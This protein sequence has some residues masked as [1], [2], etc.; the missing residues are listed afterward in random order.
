MA[1]NLAKW[2]LGADGVIL[3]KSGGGI[4]EVAMG[5]GAQ[6]CEERGIKTAIALA[7]F[8]TTLTEADSRTLFSHP[9]F[10]AIVSLGTPWSLI[11]LPPVERIIGTSVPSPGDP[12][13]D[14]KLETLLV[15]TRGLLSQTGG[16]RLTAV[17]Y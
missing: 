14:G 2:T 9:E 7:H 13:V 3:T 6:R 5:L 11:T 17:G 12:P 1:A 10:D 16:T 8:P 4:P 15:F